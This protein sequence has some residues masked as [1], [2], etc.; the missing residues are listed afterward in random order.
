MFERLFVS[1]TCSAGL[2]TLAIYALEG[3]TSRGVD[4]GFGA[5]MAI[6]ITLAV[7]ML[8]RKGRRR[9]ARVASG[10]RSN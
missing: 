5:G 6:V 3:E 9:D 4:M 8:V 10:K 7:D 1:T 2:V